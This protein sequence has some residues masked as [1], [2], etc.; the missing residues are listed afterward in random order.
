MDQDK[1]TGPGRRQR[2]TPLFSRF[3]FRGRRMHSRRKE[4]DQNYYV[5]R[6][7]FK[8]LF[9]I[10][11][12]IILSIFDA[13]LTLNL[14]QRGGTELNPF[15]SMLIDKNSMLF[16]AVKIAITS[17]CILFLLIHKNFRFFG[18]IRLNHFIYSVFSLYV[19]LI[20]YE[21]YLYVTHL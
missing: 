10:L 17:I 3:A 19:V 5:D 18:K 7:G 11:G 14:L 20:V 15:M 9:W 1:R 4:N 8:Y 16:M 21:V 13:Y 6:Y 12:I 2:P